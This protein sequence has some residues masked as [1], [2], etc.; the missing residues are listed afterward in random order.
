MP[1]KVVT[2]DGQFLLR[3]AKT[4]SVPGKAGHYVVIRSERLVRSLTGADGLR[5]LA[6]S[7]SGT[8]FS[9]PV[10]VLLHTILDLVPGHRFIPA[11]R[12]FPVCVHQ[13]AAH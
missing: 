11:N 3:A 8:D 13:P 2:S 12:R 4:A 1:N 6:F 7:P 5:P 10:A 9:D